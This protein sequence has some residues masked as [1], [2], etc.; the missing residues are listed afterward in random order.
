MTNSQ[1]RQHGITKHKLL[2]YQ[3]IVALY[4]EYKNE[5]ISTAQ[6]LRKYIYPIYPIS[7]TTLYEA[8]NTPVEREMKKIEAVEA[9]QFS[10]F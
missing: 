4:N 9:Q 5:D 10:M 2:R 1:K 8:L 6:V 7:R 3:K